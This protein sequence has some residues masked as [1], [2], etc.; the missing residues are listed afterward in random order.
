MNT[1]LS[2]V[3]FLI[4]IC[5]S[6]SPS[7]ANDFAYDRDEQIRRD[8]QKLVDLDHRNREAAAERWEKNNPKSRSSSPADA[9]T[10]L[11]GVVL[12]L[13]FVVSFVKN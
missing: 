6:F 13:V 1:F 10:V 9:S 3:A 8:A 7:P 2:L 12:V 4:L 11:F 5:G